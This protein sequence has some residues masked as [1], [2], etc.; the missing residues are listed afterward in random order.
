MFV[1]NTA[2]IYNCI[3]Y[4]NKE[5]GG[6]NIGISS[7]ENLNLQVLS[8]DIPEG[9]SGNKPNNDGYSIMKERIHVYYSNVGYTDADNNAHESS[10]L[11]YGNVTYASRNNVSGDP[12]FVDESTGDYHC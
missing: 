2:E 1:Y 12:N 5:E 9:S 4:N 11:V 7:P 8:V 3:I 10:S 6:R